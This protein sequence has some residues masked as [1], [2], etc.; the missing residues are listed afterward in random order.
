M[1]VN[2]SYGLMAVKQKIRKNDLADF[3][4]RDILTE[5]TKEF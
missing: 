3:C 4:W 5:R 2:R 1:F